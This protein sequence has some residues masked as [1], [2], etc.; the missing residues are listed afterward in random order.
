MKDDLELIE[1][2]IMRGISQYWESVGKNAV[3]IGGTIAG[4]TLAD[5]LVERCRN[6]TLVDEDKILGGEPLTRFPSMHKVTTM[7]EV[8]YEEIAN[9]GLSITTKEGK[10]Q[11][12]EADTIVTATSPRLNTELLKAVEG[13]VPEAYLIGIEDKE[14][15]SIMNAIGNGYRAAKAV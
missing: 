12:I 3:I 2:S 5:F 7:S 10:R 13:K 9:K 14:P 8:R 15:S 11:T 1:P 4:C 6:I